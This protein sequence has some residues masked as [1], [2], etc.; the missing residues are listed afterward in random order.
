MWEEVGRAAAT[1]ALAGG[2]PDVVLRSVDSLQVVYSQSWQYDDPPGRLADRLGI[3]PRHRRY[4]GIGGTVP[5]QLLGAAAESVLAGE[6]DV[7]MVCG[8]EALATKRR[9]A[10]EDRRPAWSHRD[11]E[12]KPFPF[13]GPFHPAEVAHDV[14][15]AWLTFA[16]FDI[17]RRAHLGV[18]PDEYRDR[19]GRLLAPMTTVAAVNPLAWFPVERTADELITPSPD[20][21]LV[22]YP[23]TKRTVAVMDVDMAFALVLASHAAADSLG[24]PLDRRVYLRSWAG[25]ND[26]AYVAE[27]PRLWESPAMRVA[28]NAALEGA[29]L[30]IDDVAHLDLYS[31]FASAVHLA[32]DALGLDPTDP[33]GTTVTGG[34]AFA[35]GP[36]SGYLGH[37]IATMAEVLRA[38]PGAVGLVSGVG[39]HLT[40]HVF[41][42]YS[43]AP[44]RLAPPDGAALQS[45]VVAQGPP[46][47][48]RDVAAGPATVA[49]YSVVHHRDGSPAWGLAVCDLPGGARCYA[50][51][52]DAGL[53]AEMEASEWV[54]RAVDLVSGGAVNHVAS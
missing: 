23:Y 12:K 32:L 46:C 19:I 27:H 44:G 50:R 21:R 52:E 34:L 10:K 42:T 30:G 36:G 13:E 2:G 54:G 33:R 29:G 38:D 41:A 4:S 6:L 15:Q 17:A 3:A 20:N 49:T 40:K 26:P 47:P 1:D 28:A 31:C 39:M 37:S 24:V 5:Q 8:A 43:T 22:G 9:L 11:P 35:G 53:L 45:S 16:T 25:A 48:I 18:D 14:F 51:V 7:A